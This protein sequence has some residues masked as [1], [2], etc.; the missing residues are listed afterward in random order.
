MAWFFFIS[1]AF[2]I[3]TYT[4][5]YWGKSWGMNNMPVFNLFT[6]VNLLFLSV[7]YFKTLEGSWARW[8]VGTLA[9]SILIL[10]GYTVLQP[11][12]IWQFPST[13]MTAQCVL[14]IALSLVY[15]YQMQQQEAVALEQNPLLWINAGVLLY[16]SSNLFLF[17]MLAVIHRTPE[18]HKYDFYT[19]HRV[20]NILAYL[21]FAV[22]LLC[23]PPRLT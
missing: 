15:F 10:T 19:I 17:M 20:V 16:F 22:G 1:G 9:A 12:Q 3:V 8:V 4:T 11:G 7:L 5:P 14:F 21:L 13:V 23:K 2:D 18:L 6:V